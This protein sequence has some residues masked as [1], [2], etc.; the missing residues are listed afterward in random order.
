MTPHDVVAQILGQDQKANN[1]PWRDGNYKAEGYFVEQL[2]LT[3]EKAVPLGQDFTMTFKYGNF[4]EASEKIAKMSGE[5][6][7]SVEVRLEAMGREFIDHGVLLEGGTKFILETMVGISTLEWIDEEEAERLANDGDPVDAPTSPYKV[8]PERQGRLIWITGPPGLGKSTSAQLLSREHGFIYYEGDCFFGLRNPYIPADVENPSLAQTKQRKLVGKG[9]AERREICN[10]AVKQWELKMAGKEYDVAA[11]EGMYRE[12]CKDIARTRARI[13]GDWAIATVLDSPRIRDFVRGELG[14]E[15]EI[16]VLSMT[17]EEQKARIRGRH[18]GNEDAVGLMEVFF[19]MCKPAGEDEPRTMGLTVTPEMTPHDVVAQILGQDQKANNTPWRDGNY[20]AEGYFVEQLVLTKEKAVPLGQDFTMTFKY[21]DFG[22]MSEKIAE[23]SGEKNYSVE[24]RLEA[25]GREFI[26]HG[27]L[28]EGG[29]KFILETMVG[30]STLEWI[31][32]E[33]AERLANDGDPLDAPT[34]PYKIEPERQGRL[35]W[36]TG[37][38]GLGKST[39]AQLLSREHGFVYYEGDCFFGLRNPYI[40]ADVE[41]LSL[42]QA[43]QRKFVGEGVKERKA[44]CDASVKQWEA[45]L[46]G[47]EADVGALEAMYR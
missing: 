35:I 9:V 38:P 42:A 37:P 39:S 27:V 4:G 45:M 40:P 13:G 17:L 36:I 18:E 7:Y 11:E 43:K 29:T 24:V 16:V 28:L 20:K 1:T 19:D 47:K 22:E 12:M 3:K 33:E 8:E 10:Q 23:M 30:V 21:G 34:S 25:M 14:P 5:K 31:D 6:N 26:A 2:V 41:N 32:E 44:I 46:E 15:L